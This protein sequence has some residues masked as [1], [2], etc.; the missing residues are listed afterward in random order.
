[1]APAYNAHQPLALF[2]NHLQG[3]IFE[4]YS[5]ACCIQQYVAND[6]DRLCDI[7]FGDVV[8]SQATAVIGFFEKV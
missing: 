4:G 5:R 1:M 3:F 2:F 8:I 7:E 6:V